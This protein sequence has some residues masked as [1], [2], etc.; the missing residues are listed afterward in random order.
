MKSQGTWQLLS[1]LS[2]FSAV[3]VTTVQSI[4]IMK[5][6]SVADFG[7]LSIIVSIASF[8]GVGQNLGIG[9]ATTREVSSGYDST[10]T[11]KIFIVSVITRLSVG[12]PLMVVL[13]LGSWFIANSVYSYPQMAFP[14][15]VMALVFVFHGIN[16]VISATL[17]GLKKFYLVFFIENFSAILSLF[18]YFF[19]IKIY[20]FNGYFYATL[21][22]VIVVMV[23][24]LFFMYKSLHWNYR[25]PSMNEFK[26]IF[27]SIWGLSIA[28]Y[29]SR[30]VNSGW[31]R[32]SVVLIS[33][34]VPKE[35]LG[36]LTF[37]LDYG[38]KLTAAS[39]AINTINLS[40][41]SELFMHRIEDYKKKIVKSF[42]REF[43][44]LSFSSALAICFAPELIALVFQEKYA[45][46]VWL[47][48][49][50]VIAF[51]SFTIYDV[52]RTE[53]LLTMNMKKHIVSTS[54]LMVTIT[55]IL[56]PLTYLLTR[57]VAAALVGMIG[58]AL[59]GM[60]VIVWIL[61]KEH[62]ISL[63]TRF[64]VIPLLFL[65]PLVLLGMGEFSLL[66]K[67]IF[68]FLVTSVYLY[69]LNRW[70][71]VEVML[72]L[73]RGFAFFKMSLPLK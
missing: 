59:V 41:M 69:I 16:G 29:V 58:G 22:L 35:A 32:L 12:L 46:S 73:K 47:I 55:M 26:N 53:I 68:V 51:L 62:G 44:F 38:N 7:L 48:P 60:L 39:D 66:L 6:L 23:F 37:S 30:L 40:V 3:T 33:L 19:L 61:Y 43:A 13:V 28:E 20:G 36:F 9:A 25:L 2:K 45:P 5:I 56:T 1:I 57:S 42:N 15:R 34:F 49:L 10:Q 71:I 27:R 11:H 64:N 54:L 65:S 17:Q 63:F 67:G 21:F 24:G 72:I 31:Q 70:R 18:L 8:I 50:A 4:I 52:L 14:L